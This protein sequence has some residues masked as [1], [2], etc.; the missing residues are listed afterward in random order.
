[1]ASGKDAVV[2]ASVGGLTC[3]PRGFVAVVLAESFTWTV[4]EEEPVVVGVPEMTPA[5]E[6]LSP[7][8]RDPVATDH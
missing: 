1:M 7:A 8:G 5:G 2:T 6:R 3:M 4:N